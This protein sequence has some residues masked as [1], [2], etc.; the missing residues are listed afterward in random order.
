MNYVERYIYAVT[1][2]LP[3]KQRE[4]IGKE[5][6]GL[7][8]DMLSE[9]AGDS[10][11]TEKD[12]EAVLVELGEPALLA[13][14]YMDAKR[15]LIGPENFDNYLLVLKIVVAAV[16]VGMTIALA[17]GYAVSP[18][19]N[20]AGAL[21]NFIASILS[22]I[23]QAFA[24]VTFIFALIEHFGTDVVPSK[25]WK[26]ADLPQVPEKSALI[27]PVGPIVGIVFAVLFIILFNFSSELMG[28]Y[29]IEN[30]KLSTVIPLFNKDVLSG[31]LPLINVFFA[32]A[33]IKEYIK[34]ITGKWTISLAAVNAV[35]NAVSLV[36]SIV[37]FTNPGI[38]NGEFTLQ[39]LKA[40]TIPVEIDINMFW[41]MFTNGLIFILA[42]AF[43]LDSIT[44]LLKARK[45]RV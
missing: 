27:K 37:I 29:F 43:I 35:L 28:A 34:L 2:R 14:K 26:P 12:I 44:A 20:F 31:Y 42:F 15:C 40:S 3:V 7:I 19:E 21:G 25:G 24:W 32:L 41:R 16:A 33:I 11:P 22:A 36:I 10:E 6:R 30:G 38:W 23:I 8:E 4:E 17:I 5:L 9:H 18:P 45:Q 1:K 13:D 39:L